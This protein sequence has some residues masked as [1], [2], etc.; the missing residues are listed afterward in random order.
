LHHSTGKKDWICDLPITGTVR[1]VDL[2]ERYTRGRKLIVAVSDGAS[3]PIYLQSSENPLGVMEDA[4]WVTIPT[5]ELP[6]SI[7]GYDAADAVVWFDADPG[8]LRAGGDDK[9]KALEQYVRHGGRLV[10]CQPFDWQKI[11]GFEN[12][13]PVTLQGIEQ[14]D[15]L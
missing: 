5:R 10:I 12:L 15:D 13:L 14:K 1:N 6:E 4:D 8:L 11:V 3:K 9:F 2:P 7:L